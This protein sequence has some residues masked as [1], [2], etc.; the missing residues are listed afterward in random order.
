LLM[1]AKDGTVHLSH[2]AGATETRGI[3][4]G[5]QLVGATLR[6]DG[7]TVATAGAD[8]YVRVW[9][10]ATGARLLEV[11]AGLGLTSVALDPTGHLVAAGVGPT[12][13]I[14]DAGTGKQLG[15]LAGHTD[16]VT[17]VAFSPDGT[18]LASSSRD[19]DAR[20]WDPKALKLVRL[21]RRHTAFVSGVAFSPD[22]RWLATA[23]PS[24]AGIWAVRQSDL[25]GSFLQFVRGNTTPI[26]AVAFSS[27]GW[28]LATAARDGSIRIAA[29]KLCGGLHELQSYANARLANLRP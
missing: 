10:T 19:R 2:D 13:A 8:G 27:R 29:C 28:E 9:D 23:G 14:Y 16:T 22:G 21:L 6:T 1:G 15:V 17:G 5:S 4:H 7:A 12:I 26:A 20:V 25:P 18:L 24:K 11:R 3:V